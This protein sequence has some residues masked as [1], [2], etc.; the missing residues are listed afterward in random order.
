MQQ[1]FNT[2]DLLAPPEKPIKFDDYMIARNKWDDQFDKLKTEKQPELRAL[3][4]FF[5]Q[6]PYNFNTI[7]HSL[8]L[9]YRAL[10]MEPT[11]IEKTV[12]TICRE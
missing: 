12:A 4:E 5:S 7:F 1:N 11:A 2:F 6:P 9:K 3:E 8:K 10:I